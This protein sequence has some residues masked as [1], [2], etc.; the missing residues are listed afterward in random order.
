MAYLP[1]RGSIYLKAGSSTHLVEHLCQL[2]HMPTTDS[3]SIF[4]NQFADRFKARTNGL[5]VRTDTADHF[6]TD[7]V[8]YGWIRLV[9]DS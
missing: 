9:P 2:S 7:L 1:N 8:S 5:I 4:M 6:I 3:L